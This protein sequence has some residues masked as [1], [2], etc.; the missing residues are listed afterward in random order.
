MPHGKSI[1]LSMSCQIYKMCAD[2]HVD[3][4]WKFDNV[5]D[6]PEYGQILGKQMCIYHAKDQKN[7]SDDFSHDKSSPLMKGRLG[8]FVEG[9][10]LGDGRW[11]KVFCFILPIPWCKTP[12]GGFAV[13]TLQSRLASAQKKP[14]FFLANKWGILQCLQQKLLLEV[15][16]L[17]FAVLLQK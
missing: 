16:D 17:Q 9:K 4:E 2:G 1:A 6:G 14:A 15:W 8:W 13:K 10:A 12:K 3:D 11:W 7:P 5:I